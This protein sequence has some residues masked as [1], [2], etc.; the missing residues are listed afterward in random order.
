MALIEAKNVHKTYGDAADRLDV[1]KGVDWRIETGEAWAVL[2]ASGA[3]KSTLLHILGTLDKP[4]AGLVTFEGVNLFA[5][6][7]KELSR[8]RNRSMGFVFQFHHLLPMLSARENVMLPAMIAGTAKAEAETKAEALLQR[9]GLAARLAHRPGELSGGEQQRVAI[10]RALVMEPRV[11]F[12]DEPTGNLDSR[13]GEE[14]ADLMLE[15]HHEKQM[16]LVVVTHNDRLAQRL[17]RRLKMSDGRVE[18]W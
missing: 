4:S 6:S 18:P 5:R 16:T 11:L 15:L 14:V 7:D 17:P 3:G 9:V 2:G 13:S 1:L 10:A 12:A 8:F